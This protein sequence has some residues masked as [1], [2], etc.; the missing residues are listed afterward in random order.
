MSE[1]KSATDWLTRQHDAL[2]DI[3][4]IAAML[5]G[6]GNSFHDVG[7]HAVGKRLMGFAE[8]LR[9]DCTAIHNATSD[10]LSREIADGEKT[11]GS[12][13]SAVIGMRMQAPTE[14]L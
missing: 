11:I 7:N 10:R 1:D 13:L 6:L 8:D 5:I 9:A 4:S 3:D 2:R 14:R 12:V